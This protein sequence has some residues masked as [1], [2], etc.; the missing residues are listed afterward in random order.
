MSKIAIFNGASVVT[1][2]AGGVGACAAT[3]P[4]NDKNNSVKIKFRAL[5]KVS[6]LSFTKVSAARF[7]NK[8]RK[9]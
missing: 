5:I 4:E 9:K 6:I 2:V 1:T 8:K 3:V 7:G